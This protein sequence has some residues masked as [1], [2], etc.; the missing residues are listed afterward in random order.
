MLAPQ[1]LAVMAVLGAAPF[2]MAYPADPQTWIVHHSGQ[3]KKTKQFCQYFDI[4]QIGS[5][6]IKISVK[7][8]TFF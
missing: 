8:L 6:P 3:V 4:Y 7:I 1:C 2:L 5:F